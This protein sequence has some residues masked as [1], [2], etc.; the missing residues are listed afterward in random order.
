LS[1]AA[2]SPVTFTATATPGP[3]TA[4]VRVLNNSFDPKAITVAAGTTVTWIWSST[5]QNH[6]VAPDGTMPTRSGDPVNGPTSYQFKFD[7]PGTYQYHCEAHGAPGGIGM[8][9]TVTVQ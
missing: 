9:G 7:T 8:S 2:G 1:G 6:N 4:S 5:A 3:T